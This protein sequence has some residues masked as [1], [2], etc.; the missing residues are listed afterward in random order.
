MVGYPVV[1]DEIMAP[2]LIIER[3]FS[4]DTTISYGRLEDLDHDGDLDLIAS[5]GHPGQAY[6]HFTYAFIEGYG[7]G[8]FST[9]LTPLPDNGLRLM[10]LVDVDHD[11]DL[12][13]L[14]AGPNNVSWLENRTSA[15]V[16]MGMV[17]IDP[18]NLVVKG[19]QVELTLPGS[20]TGPFQLR[21]LDQTGKCVFRQVGIDHVIRI[22]LEALAS[23]V[24]LLNVDEARSGSAIMRAKFV[25]IGYR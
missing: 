25:L 15:Q 22:N 23:G 6:D 20:A 5:T 17:H 1:S 7:A 9:S 13:L 4:A 21:V 2:T 24:Y 3:T 19:G 18:T 14:L 10:D 11:L 8:T 12:D 16:G